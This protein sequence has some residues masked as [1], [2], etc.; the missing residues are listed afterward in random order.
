[1]TPTDFYVLL[2]KVL[3]TYG[4]APKISRQYSCEV[5]MLLKIDVL[6]G[7][8]VVIKSIKDWECLGICKQETLPLQGSED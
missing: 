2:K 3:K 6:G 1:M 8:P 4:S 5:T 7:I